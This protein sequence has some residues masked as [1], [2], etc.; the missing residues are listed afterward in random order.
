MSK[1]LNLCQFIG[2]IGKDIELRYTANGG[3]VASF[4]IAC[5]D[6][7]KDKNGAKVEQVNWV[8]I[9]AFGK[10][11][12]LINQYTGK[13]SKI[14]V[15]GKLTVRKWE[16]DTKGTQYSTEVVANEM[17]FLDSKGDSPQRSQPQNQMNDSDG[18]APAG[19]DGF[20]DIP[21]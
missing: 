3:A 6:D 2:R 1:D 12:E 10:A 5:G 8:N 17:Q 20:D 19:D 14:Y 13:G 11:G 15:S 18:P 4:S 21:F 16:H 7:Y 9:V